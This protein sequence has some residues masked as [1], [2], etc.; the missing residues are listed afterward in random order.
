MARLHADERER[1]PVVALEADRLDRGRADAGRAR[2]QLVEATHAERARVLTV[3]VDERAVAYDV[4]GDDH[5]AGARQL[6]RELEVLG[7]VA[8]VGIDE[9]QI[10]R[11]RALVDQLAESV[12]RRADPDFYEAGEAGPFGVRAGDLGV[13]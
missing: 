8:L 13:A 4:V 11:S 7:G 12:E 10:E 9:R 1:E 5:A 3:G 6:E 2:E